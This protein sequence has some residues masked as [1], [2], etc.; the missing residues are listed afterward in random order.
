MGGVILIMG[1]VTL[2]AWGLGFGPFAAGRV[3]TL[4]SSIEVAGAVG[5]RAQIRDE[6]RFPLINVR[7]V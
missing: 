1:V 7:R 3:M 2:A 5:G 6:E 4:P